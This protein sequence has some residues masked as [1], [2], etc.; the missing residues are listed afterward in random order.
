MK[1][2][3]PL[4]SVVV[5]VRNDPF[6]LKS[7]L[8][9]ITNQSYPKSRYEVIVVDNN[10]LPGVDDIC[11]SY[12]VCCLHQPV[13][14]SYAAR[15]LGISRSLG[16]YIALLDAGCIPD[17]DWLEAGI[18]YITRP[19]ID[20]VG[21]RINFSFKTSHPNIYE[22]LDSVRKLD[23][24]GYVR[25]GFSVTANMF[26]DRNVFAHFG[27]FDSSLFSGGDYEFGRRITIGGARLIYGPAAAVTHPAR[28]SLNQ[29][30]K[31]TIRVSLGQ[32]Q[33]ARMGKLG[34]GRLDLFSFLPL[35]Q[36]P[37]GRYYS[38][39]SRPERFQIWLLINLIRYLNVFYRLT[40]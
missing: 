16:K 31:K 25:Q 24:E 26:I 19:K 39:L 38:R 13:P 35:L 7:T 28:Y 30:L 36:I 21:G 4:I 2:P 32:K 22:Y 15:N 9:S 27:M 3:K 20:A 14:G 33:L 37:K 23:Q 18:R 11:R 29:I 34:H 1:K 8:T 17:S 5:P 40:P 6:G 12:Q 10:S